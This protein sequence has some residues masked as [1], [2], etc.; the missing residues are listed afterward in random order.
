MGGG[1]ERYRQFRVLIIWFVDIR[2]LGS[3][4][5]SHQRP[6]M[7]TESAENIQDPTRLLKPDGGLGTRIAGQGDPS[8]LRQ[9]FPW[10]GGRAG[11]A[12]W[13]DGAAPDAYLVTTVLLIR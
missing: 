4:G 13:C 10:R 5:Q 2:S 8:S 12:R 3:D 7:A 6:S 11:R 1:G 9:S